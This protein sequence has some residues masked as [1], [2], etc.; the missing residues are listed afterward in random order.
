LLRL[1]T[2]HADLLRLRAEID[3]LKQRTPRQ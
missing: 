2:D 1:R 3:A